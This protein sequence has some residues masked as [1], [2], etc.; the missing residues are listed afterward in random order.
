MIETRQLTRELDEVREIL[1]GLAVQEDDP[2]GVE[3]V[4]RLQYVV[5]N[6]YERLQLSDRRLISA[7]ILPP[8]NLPTQQV[9]E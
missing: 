5:A 4:D 1:K 6:L 3:I 9:R 8:A 2:E 7:H